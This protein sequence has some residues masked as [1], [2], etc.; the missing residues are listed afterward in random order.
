M[1]SPTVTSRR[2]WTRIRHRGTL[3]YKE[4]IQNSIMCILNRLYALYYCVVTTISLHCCSSLSAIM[5][6]MT[7][8]LLLL[9]LFVLPFHHDSSRRLLCSCWGGPS[10]K[11]TEAS[12]ATRPRRRTHSRPL[13]HPLRCCCIVFCTAGDPAIT[14]AN[15]HWY[16]NS[17]PTSVTVSGSTMVVRLEQ[18]SAKRSPIVCRAVCCRSTLRILLHSSINRLP[19]VVRDGGNSIVVTFE[20]S[21]RKP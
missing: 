16:W 5:M 6:M 15:S 10:S 13:Y 18:P 1:G 19:I 21:E 8:L 2:G 7:L 20:H 3:S 17:S 14:C 4:I 11:D 12:T 9:L